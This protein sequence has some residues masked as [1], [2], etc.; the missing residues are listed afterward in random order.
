M[1]SV[2]AKLPLLARLLLGLLF[3]VFGLNGFLHFIAMQPPTGAAG[4]YL[5]GLMAAGYFFPLLKGTEIVVGIALLSGRY[6][7]LAL[8]ILAPITVQIVAYHLFLAP[9]GIG[10]TLVILALHLYLAWV[11]RDAFQPLLR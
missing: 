9:A 10:M 11:Y 3:V 5:G 2:L 6:V 1:S 8:T 7:P 4:R